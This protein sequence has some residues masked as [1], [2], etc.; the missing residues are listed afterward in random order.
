MR[1]L[2]HF[3]Q[4]MSPVSA[5]DQKGPSPCRLRV[6]KSEF[7]IVGDTARSKSTKPFPTTN[8]QPTYGIAKTRVVDEQRRK[9]PERVNNYEMWK[10]GC[11]GKFKMVGMKNVEDTGGDDR[12]GR[13]VGVPHQG[14]EA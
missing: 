11:W 5:G 10:S 8:S 14:M 3:Q 4:V 9:T 1:P 7:T 6:I 2:S 13:R 12:D